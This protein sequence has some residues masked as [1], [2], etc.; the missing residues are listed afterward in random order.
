MILNCIVKEGLTVKVTFQEKSKGSKG[1][2]HKDIWSE[3]SQ[4]KGKMKAKVLS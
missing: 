1:V 3:S 2:S 4:G